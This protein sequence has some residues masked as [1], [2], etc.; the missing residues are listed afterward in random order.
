[1]AVA[2]ERNRL[3]QVG[4]QHGRRADGDEVGSGTGGGDVSRF[5]WNVNPMAHGKVEA[6]AEVGRNLMTGSISLTS[7]LMAKRRGSNFISVCP[8]RKEGESAMD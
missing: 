2:Y 4:R 6:V 8:D 1:M 5:G 3:A 7:D